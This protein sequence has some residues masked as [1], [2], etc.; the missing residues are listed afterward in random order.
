MSKAI[1]INPITIKRVE[2]DVE[3]LRTEDGGAVLCK[4]SVVCTVGARLRHAA[5]R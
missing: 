2:G 3:I 5:F 1:F 4:G